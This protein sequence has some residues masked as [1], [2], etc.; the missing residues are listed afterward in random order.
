MNLFDQLVQQALSNIPDLAPL[1]VVVEKELLHHDIVRILS[2][3]GML[4]GLCFIGASENPNPKKTDLMVGFFVP[5][6]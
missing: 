4:Q 2:E 5:N 1:Q 3:S 6:D